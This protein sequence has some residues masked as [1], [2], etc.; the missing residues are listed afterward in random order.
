MSIKFFYKIID[1]L[2][3][4]DL[5]PVEVAIS[6]LLTI[7]GFFLFFPVVPDII[8]FEG[9]GLTREFL[10]LI[11]FVTGTASLYN[12]HGRNNVT[13]R[14]T[15]LLATVIVFMFLTLVAGMSTGFISI[16]WI[17]RLFFVLLAGMCHISL[18]AGSGF[19]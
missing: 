13:F 12:L 3:K 18:T 7:V 9:L 6:G 1:R 8:V 5:W 4:N 11:M 17:M 15:I 2:G 19:E 10:A 16:T 14:K